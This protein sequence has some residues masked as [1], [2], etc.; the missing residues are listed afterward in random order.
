MT[1]RIENIGDIAAATTT[2]GMTG[3]YFF[4]IFDK[5]I[6]PVLA[7]IVSILTIVWLIYRIYE[8]HNKMNG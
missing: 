8:I 7:G 6:N 5:I 2:L 1:K 3:H 4:E